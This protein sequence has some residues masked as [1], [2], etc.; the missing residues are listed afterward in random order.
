M[1]GEGVL[2]HAYDN[3]L[4]DR[5]HSSFPGAGK[6]SSKPKL[7][8]P[9]TIARTV[10][11]SSQ[12]TDWKC[13]N[14]G[15]ERQRCMFL[16][17]KSCFTSSADFAFDLLTDSTND[18]WCQNKPRRQHFVCFLVFIT[19]LVLTITFR[20]TNPNYFAVDFKKIQAE[21]NLAPQL[22]SY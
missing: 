20:V 1:C 6:C 3:N 14:H 7:G 15:R 10:G 19:L 2:L 4:P 17:L 16:N 21:V 8:F 13:G 18:G 5:E 22:L 12:H 11:P 9:L